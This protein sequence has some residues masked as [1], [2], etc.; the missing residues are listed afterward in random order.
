[1]GFSTK[2]LNNVAR[3]AEFKPGTTVS[4]SAGS[5]CILGALRIKT[6]YKPK[7]L[8]PKP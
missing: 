8:N 7:A 1:M 2:A 5:S 6:S 4:P 3:A